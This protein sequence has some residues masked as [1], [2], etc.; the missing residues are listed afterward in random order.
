MNVEKQMKKFPMIVRTV[1]LL[2]VT[3]AALLPAGAAFAQEWEEGELDA[4]EIEI[5]R[6]RE[7]TL[8]KANRNFEK[9]PPRPSETIK[10]PV[11]YDF[12][13]FS[14]QTSQINPAIRPL[15]LKQG[16]SSQVYGGYVSAGYGNYASPYLEGFINS[17]RDKNKLVGAHAWLNTSGKG[18]VDGRNSGSGTSGVSLY[19][20]AFS[21]YIAFSADLD[22]ENRSTHFYGYEPGFDVEPSDIRQSYN[23]FK[24]SGDLSNTKNRAFTYKLGGAFS[25][26]AD[27]FKARETEVDIEFNSAYKLGTTSSIGI[28]ADYSIINR[29]DELVEATPRSLFSIN[30]TYVFYPVEDL[31]MS[32]GIVAAFENDSIDDKDVHAY[33]DIHISYPLTPSIDMVA[34]LTGGI[35]KVSLQSLSR[36]NLWLAPNVPVFHT[37]KLFDLQA[38]LHTKIGNKVAVNAGFSFASLKNWYFFV[39]TPFVDS[40]LDQAK[41]VPEYDRGATERTNFFASFGFA[42]SESAKFLLR[43]DLYS[44]SSDEVQEAWHRPKYKVTG[45]VSFNIYKKLLLDVNLIA[46]GGMKAWDRQTDATV[47]LDPAFDLN[48]RAEYVLSDSFSIWVQANNITSNKY[49]I[50]LNYPVRGLQVLGGLTWSF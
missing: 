22:F 28:A 43:G 7:I 4:V 42:Q 46:Q 35:E 13:P 20:K 6:E 16:S 38:A 9:I 33:P 18:P 29:T 2:M 24:L 44:Y 34:V 12:R 25:Y 48:A 3:M 39:N 40:P 32:A 19:G 49:P 26:M 27:R 17:R 37:N 36:E 45:D 15:K 47:D 30:P 31:R 50:F 11:Q 1:C 8:P 23:T 5:V 14:F 10:N 21:E 41:F